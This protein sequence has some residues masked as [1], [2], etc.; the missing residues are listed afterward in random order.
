MPGGGALE[1]ILQALP[2]DRP[3]LAHDALA[4]ELEEVERGERHGAA[5]PVA[6][7]EDG[8]DALAA[9]AGHGLTVED[10]RR[11][12]PADVAE[13]GQPWK[14]DQLPA[15]AAE[16]VDGAMVA[17]VELGALA[18]E[19]GLGAVARVREPTRI[20]QAGGEH[21]GDEGH[22]GSSI[23]ATA[24]S[25]SRPYPSG[26]TCPGHGLADDGAP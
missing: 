9:V 14:A 12:R 18:V 1:Q 11:D 22:G 15:R 26:H 17:H 23:V 21:R 7:L 8:L 4:V 25:R 2:P 5:R 16:R 6:R 19:L 24:P 3:R 20:F 13:P 10:G